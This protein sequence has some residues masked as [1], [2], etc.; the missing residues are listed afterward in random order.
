M[1]TATI[2]PHD[3][4]PAG[5][6]DSVGLGPI[7]VASEG[8]TASDPALQAA[9]LL[10]FDSATRVVVLSV[11]EPTPALALDYAILPPIPDEASPGDNRSR[12]VNDQL[13]RVGAAASRWTVDLQD[14]DAACVI[15]RR[16]NELHAELVIV[17]I[18]HHDLLDRVIGEETA[19]RTLRA[20]NAPVLAVSSNFKNLPTRVLVATDFSV[21]SIEAARTAMRFFESISLIYLVHV[22]PRVGLQPEAFAAWE[23]LYGESLTTQFERASAELGDH[24]GVTVETMTL[25][26]KASHELLRF[27][28][29]TKVDLIVSGSSGAG[30]I[31]RLLVG[32]TATGLI[33]GAK[34][35]V[36]TVPGALGSERLIG[37]P[38][39]PSLS[40]DRWSSEL[41]AFSGRNA[42]RCTRLEVDDPDAGAQTLERG[43]PL[44]G[45]DYDQ[46][47][48]RVEIIL[49]KAGGIHR[50]LTHSLTD[51]QS[52][53]LLRDHRGRDAAV[54]MQD[55][56][57]QTVLSFEM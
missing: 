46:S 7:V 55:G 42:N 35:S 40:E 16:A 41:A 37:G 24:P 10:A 8:T 49:G 43:L 44:L 51:V 53:E 38:L 18:G 48:H 3:S 36:L 52:I 26:G 5:G 31:D 20:C 30:F 23:M 12:V 2:I 14:G 47:A 34:C 25:E 54:R 19:L 9:K 21:G 15:A 6:K 28:L 11:L 22:K 32:S 17:G 1:S 4:L 27:A 39:K 33:R 50:H 45:I 13:A 57:G 56:R 29:E